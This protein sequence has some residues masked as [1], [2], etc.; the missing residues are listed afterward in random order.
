MTDQGSPP[1]AAP[2]DTDTRSAHD[3]AQARTWAP[4]P[5]KPYVIVLIV[6]LAALAV[7]AILAAFRL[8]PF[9]SGG[10]ETDNAYVEGATTVLSPQVSG[11]VKQV[12]VGDYAHVHAGDLL[13]LIDDSSYRARVM[14]AA[15]GVKATQAQLANNL[16]QLASARAS[17]EGKRA[18]LSAAVAQQAN[19]ESEMRR[20]D[21]LV[22]DGSVSRRERDQAEV[23][24]RQARGT[25]GQARAAVDVAVEDE[26][27]VQVARAGLQAQVDQ[28]NAVLYAAK[29]DLGHTRIYAPADGQLGRVSVQVGAYVVIGSQLFSLVPPARWV[30]AQYKEAQTHGLRVG[31]RATFTVDA[32]GGRRFDGLVERIAPATESEFS[33]VKLDNATGNFVKVPQR[34]GVRISIDKDQ[35]FEDRLRPGMSVETWI[36]DQI[37]RG[38]AQDRPK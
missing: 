1:R 2:A 22:T 35:P 37:A 32:L 19:A 33:A 26:R 27:T 14:Q 7:S 3:H 10:S 21:D 16:Q 15:A 13:V 17:L 8:P 11:Y 23:N 5:K 28:A 9:S 38:A 18:A 36:G 25:A 12:A 31:Q 4:P 29:I 24:D 20:D 34:I 30:V 6:G